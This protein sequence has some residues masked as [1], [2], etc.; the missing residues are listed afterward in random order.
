MMITPVCPNLLAASIQA[1]LS[2]VLS[3]DTMAGKTALNVK[4]GIIEQ[5]SEGLDVRMSYLMG[6]KEAKTTQKVNHQEKTSN[7]RRGEKQTISPFYP[8]DRRP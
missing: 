8:T 1:L 7:G 6:A 5:S 3:Q 4:W 2:L